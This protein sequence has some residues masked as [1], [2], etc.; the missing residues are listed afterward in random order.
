M[1][2]TGLLVGA[3]LAKPLSAQSPV[4]RAPSTEISWLKEVQLPPAQVV[5]SSSSLSA[6]LV[7]EEGRPIGS[8]EEW[9]RRRVQLEKLWQDF[10]GTLEVQRHPTPQLSLVVEDR[11]GDVIRQLVRYEVEPGV[12]TEAYLLKPVKAKRRAGVVAFH[13]T[14]DY[15]IRQPAGIEGK[16]EEAFGLKLAERGYVTFCPRNYLWPDNTHI[17]AGEEVARFLKRHPRAKGMAKMLFDAQV[18]V[19]ILA[20]QPEIDP[21]RLGAIGHSLG[22]KEVLYLAAFDARIQVAI[23]SEGGIGTT[24]SNWNAAWYLGDTIERPTSCENITSC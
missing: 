14:I 6:L 4:A 8:L 13:S 23:C 19:D 17:A 11:V 7:N 3:G 9:E 24:F 1:L 18:A 2:A 16:S 10:L 15:S 20:S 21:T 12:V 5:G 22:A